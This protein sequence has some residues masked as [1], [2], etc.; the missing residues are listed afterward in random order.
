MRMCRRVYDLCTS[1]ILLHKCD[2]LYCGNTN[3]NDKQEKL[4]ENL[5]GSKFDLDFKKY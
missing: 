3:I 4:N 1:K 2:A 5:L